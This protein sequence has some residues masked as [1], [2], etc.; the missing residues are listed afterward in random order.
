[1][2]NRELLTLA[3]QTLRPHSEKGRIFGDVAAAL[4]SATGHIF[5]GV[6]VD[7]PSWGICAERNALAAMITAGEY[8]FQKIVAV[9]KDPASGLFLILPPCGVCREFM[10]CINE[11]NLNSK[12]ILSEERVA[13]LKDLLPEHAWPDKESS[14]F[15]L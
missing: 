14:G 12:V 5:T 9:W 6:S 8:R 11:E 15:S 7:T 2:N 1:M 10:R 4:V 13:L 3:S